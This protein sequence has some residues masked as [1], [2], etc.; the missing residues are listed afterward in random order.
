[1]LS[2]AVRQ[3]GD[4]AALPFALRALGAGLLIDLV[5]GALTGLGSSPRRT[6]ASSSS[7][8]NGSHIAARMPA[9]MLTA[10]TESLPSPTTDAIAR[11]GLISLSTLA[12]SAS[13][14]ATPTPRPAQPAPA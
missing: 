5:T 6:E 9:R 14:P 11:V 10:R 3:V 13:G 7:T 8:A 4:K 2:F 1:M 12:C